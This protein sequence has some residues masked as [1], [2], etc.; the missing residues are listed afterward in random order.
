V[1]CIIPVI[2]AITILMRCVHED[3]L[4]SLTV[5]VKKLYWLLT[6]PL[7]NVFA[8]RKMHIYNVILYCDKRQKRRRGLQ[9]RLQ[10]S[11]E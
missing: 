7:G 10:A 4:L 8:P 5:I 9:A 6:K 3:K 2:L 1:I 11:Q